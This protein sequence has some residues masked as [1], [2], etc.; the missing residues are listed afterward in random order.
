MN[1][2]IQT[3]EDSTTETV[4]KIGQYSLIKDSE[5]IG[6]HVD[7]GNGP[8][9]ISNFFINLLK[10]NRGFR[11]REPFAYYEG[12]VVLSDGNKISFDSLSASCFAEPSLLHKYLEH[13]CGAKAI[14]YGTSRDLAKAIKLLN[15]NTEEFEEKEFGYNEE[16][17]T[18]YTEDLII[19]A[20]EILKKNTPIKFSENWGNNKLG[21]NVTETK[22]L[23]EIKNFIIDKLLK[24]DEPEII[25][26]LLSFSLYPIIYPF[27]KDKNPNKF[28]LML[29][30][31]S[32]SGKSQMSKWMQSFYGDFHSLFSW[33]ST[34]TSIH[35]TGMAFKD[36]VFA[37]DDL[38]QQN[39]RCETDIKRIQ[40]LIQ[41]YSDCSSRQ[42]SR[43]D[44][45]LRDAR[46]IK[47]HLLISAEDLVFAES[48][49]I[50]RGI[51]I[52]V[53]SKDCQKQELTEIEDMAKEFQSFTPYLIQHI[54]K[55][56]DKA[57]VTK[58]FDESHEWISNHPDIKGSDISLDNRHRL[59]NNF[60]ALKV[61]W[62]ILSKYLF[63]E[64]LFGADQLT[65]IFFNESLINLFLENIKRISEYRPDEVFESTLWEMIEN[66]TFILSEVDRNG[67]LGPC[68][69]PE[70]VIGYF[71]KGLNEEPRLIIN[72]KAALRELIKR[73][74]NFSI[75]A[76][77]LIAKL[78]T[79]GKITLNPSGKASL[80]GYKARGA[81]WIG[82]YPKSIIGLRDKEDPVTQ[83][84]A[85]LDEKEEINFPF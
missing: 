57:K 84:K 21:F 11:D 28:Y 20:D 59:L 58:I 22:S 68:Y 61:S 25:L 44:L 4:Q 55:N 14:I 80:N 34:D 49:T 65:E 74:P 46:I 43:V 37:I 72:I 29:K 70:K 51:I 52:N 2:T 9:R 40:G 63:S 82:E 81:T 79:D 10:C 41:N 48:S 85:I 19:T 56:F 53:E 33:T 47:G 67:N 12:E 13:L 45:I 39:F 36:A 30:G 38:K 35:V 7:R 32:G 5:E 64:K 76:D 27:V 15:S 83:A 16:L 3:M 71:T 78:K 17:T 8:S 26:P 54:L 18:Y 42:R 77:T 73:L 6:Y 23:E 31:P 66:G 1:N 75:S 60:A 24:W 69:S 50:A 62:V